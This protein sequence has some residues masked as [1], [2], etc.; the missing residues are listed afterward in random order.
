M[1]GFRCHRRVASSLAHAIAAA[2]ASTLNLPTALASSSTATEEEHSCG[3]WLAP[4]PIKEQED[5]GWGHSIF[6]GKLIPKGTVVLGSGIMDETK[7]EKVFGDL[8]IPVYDWESLDAGAYAK[9]L[10]LHDEDDDEGDAHDTYSEEQRKEQIKNAHKLG[11]GGD[12]PLFQELWN[13]DNYNNLLLESYESMRIFMPGLANIPPCSATGFNLGQVQRQITYRDW[14]DIRKDIHDESPPSFQ[15][16]SFSYLSHAMFVA[17]RDIQPGEELVVECSNNSDEFDPKDYPP[18]DFQPKE[19]GGY[20]I[21]LDDKAEERLA[22]HTPNVAGGRYGGQRGLFA[23]RTL[24]AGEIITSTPLTP[25]HRNE[26][27]MDRKKYEQWNMQAEQEHVKV[28]NIPPKK[29]Q[30]L[31]NYMFG[32]AESS[33]LWLPQ[34]PLI[35]AVNHASSYDQKKPKNVQVEPNAK[36]QWHSDKYTEAQAAG[37]PLTRRQQFHHREL[38]EMDSLAVVQKEGMGL[39]LDLVATRTIKE[40]EEILIDYGKA[41]DDAMKQHKI[42]WESTVDAIKL[43]HEQDKATRKWQRK[44]EREREELKARSIKSGLEDTRHKHRQKHMEN[45]MTA[46]PL[47]SYVTA[48]D[49]NELYG[50]DDIRTVTEQYRNPYPSNIETA[51]YFGFDWLDDEDDGDRDAEPVTYE[52]WYNQ[53]DE[54]DPGCLLPCVITERRDYIAGE[55]EKQKQYDNDDDDGYKNNERKERQSRNTEHNGGSASPKRYTVKLIDTHEENTSIGFQCHIYKRFEYVY[56]DIPREGITFINKPHST[57]HWIEQ[58]FRQPIGLPDE[59]VPKIWRDLTQ[60][61]GMRG[62][63]NVPKPKAAAAKVMT[64]KEEDA[65]KDYLLSVKRWNVVETRRERLEELDEKLQLTPRQDL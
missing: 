50:E 62:S 52:S 46:I 27:I 26:M 36:I 15:A 49:Y 31:L 25:V 45:S 57:D 60:R 56:M 48:A 65:E 44:Q 21:C 14:R 39:M 7:S 6:T 22:D 20:S 30:L 63:N 33:L 59:M 42:Q 18:V 9:M 16:G 58:A 32:H 54:L 47:S 5:H 13:G 34:A 61:K 51:C 64:E 28:G 55:E 53:E 40:G 29:Q 11:L 19:A 43:E 23:K 12:P 35:L 37:K 3:L 38:L 1:S 10:Y 4:S 24:K 41:W 2:A 17:H 8:F